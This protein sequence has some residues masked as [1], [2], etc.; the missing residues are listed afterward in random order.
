MSPVL[1]LPA[2]MAPPEV[3]ALE[4]KRHVQVLALPRRIE[5]LADVRP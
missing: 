5:R 1:Y 4:Q 2:E 3:S